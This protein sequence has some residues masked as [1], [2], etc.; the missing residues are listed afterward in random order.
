[1][2]VYRQHR[3]SKTHRKY[4]AMAKC[5]WPRAEWIS[6][7]GPYALL[8][9]CRVLTVTLHQEEDSALRYKAMID[10][11]GCGGMCVQDHEIVRLELPAS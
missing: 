6:G 2:K 7:N 9:R 11:T 3:C 5:I 10:S 4:L 1:M 8:A